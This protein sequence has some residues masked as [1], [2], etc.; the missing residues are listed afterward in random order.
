M[1]TETS[2]LA[3]RIRALEDRNEIQDVIVRYAHA[4]DE[5]DND[6]L[7]SCFTDD[8]EASFAGVPAGVGGR[9]IAAF[10]DS[11]MGTGPRVPSLHLFTNVVVALDGD[12]ADVRSNAIVYNLRTETARL[13]LRGISYHDTFVRTPTGWRIRKRVH[14]A[15]WEAA[16]DSVPL[17][18]IKPA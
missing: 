2:D 16:A 5:H 13:H 14:S 10:L 17:T 11:L 9:A 1:S 4:I 18:P 7:V 8:A 6:L 3:A 15:A 12:Q